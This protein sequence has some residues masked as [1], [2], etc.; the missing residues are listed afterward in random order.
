MTKGKWLSLRMMVNPLF[1]TTKVKRTLKRPLINSKFIPIKWSSILFCAISLAE[2]SILPKNSLK[3]SKS[4]KPSPFISISASSKTQSSLK[5]LLL[6][7]KK[8]YP[9]KTNSRSFYPLSQS[10][11]T[12]KRAKLSLNFAFLFQKYNHQR[13]FRSLTKNC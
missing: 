11:S 3:I 6:K 7:N 8:F 2:T 4:T 10:I 5:P 1:C 12:L 9:T 13:F